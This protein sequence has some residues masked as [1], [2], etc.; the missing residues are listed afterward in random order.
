MARTTP[1]LPGTWQLL[2]LISGGSTLALEVAWLK[3]FSQV[4]GADIPALT[5]VTAAL[6]LGLAA[7]NTIAARLAARV[8]SPL[9]A[10]SAV[11]IAVAVAAAFTL[12][13]LGWL[14]TFLAPLYPGHPTFSFELLRFVGASSILLVPT[15]LMGL[16]LPLL[17]EATRRRRGLPG[18][19]F[20]RL[21]AANTI[22]AALGCL[23]AGFVLIPS[24]GVTFGLLAATAGHAVNALF[25][26]RLAAGATEAEPAAAPSGRAT[27]T[28]PAAAGAGT[29][30]P[31]TSRGLA[32]L[33]P[34]LLGVP[35]I[36]YE[37]TW[38]RSLV[39][40][41]GSTTYA[42][43]ILL[44]VF[45]LGLGAGPLLVA[46][47]TDRVRHPWAWVAGLQ[48]AIAISAFGVKI[49]VGQLP[50]WVGAPLARY[51]QSFGGFMMV[52]ASIA[53]MVLIV[54][55]LLLGCAFAFAARAVQ[56]SFAS[57]G[58]GAGT[59]LGANT[60]GNTTGSLAAT[61]VLIPALGIQGSITVASAL[62]VGLGF[63]AAWL[64]KP[65][66]RTAVI[67]GAAALVWAGLAVV[68]PRW[69]PLLI[70]SGPFL[71][72]T[73]GAAN[74]GARTTTEAAGVSV[75]A[76]AEG[77]AATV[78]VM[79][80]VR[81]ERS[82]TLNGKTTAST[83]NDIPT[84]LLSGHLP[85]LLA[86]Q[87]KNV[88]VIG[89]G[90]GASAAAV[91]RH[92]VERID[93]AE[94]SP[95]VVALQP[96]FASVNRDILTDPRVRMLTID[97]RTHLTYT[98]QTYDVITSEP[99]NPW[100]AGVGNLFSREFFEACR[101]HLAPGGVHAQWLQGYGLSRHDVASVIATFRAVY[102]E[103]TI[104]EPAWGS[105]FLLVAKRDGA[106][107][108]GDLERVWSTAAA[109]LATIGIRAPDDLLMTFLGGPALAESVTD[110]TIVT[111][112]NL[113]LEFAVARRVREVTGAQ[114]LTE[115]SLATAEGVGGLRTVLR[116]DDDATG[117]L[118]RGLA[119]RR[120]AYT[121][122]ANDPS[123]R[124]EKT[125]AA[126]HADGVTPEQGLQLSRI[127][128]AGLQFEIELFR[129]AQAAFDAEDFATAQKLLEQVLVVSPDHAEALEILGESRFM[130]GNAT[131]AIEALS[132]AVARQPERWRAYNILGAALATAGRTTD[133]IA[134][135][136][137]VPRS[138][139]EPY[140]Q[141][142]TNLARARALVNGS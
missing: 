93:V 69:D 137:R 77:V 78:M 40:I 59:F 142:Q 82:L 140:E 60:L 29:A 68:V 109:D 85:L 136:E 38:S 111:D 28:R 14:P 43:S 37:A 112:D 88:L 5:A 61:F 119:R 26:F 23:V 125:L 15:T 49:L 126:L 83:V 114:Y 124:F 27:K 97:G 48:F 141:A 118:E 24:L 57:G 56:E 74:Y 73:E 12:P 117:R 103:A 63:W 50:L 120:A 98:D 72:A 110:G 80:D 4:L 3:R 34:F 87:A 139:G 55:T 18:E 90:C 25:A 100:I 134:A 133:A 2:A 67:G 39:L 113:H 13:A 22:G 52:E 130:T 92:P 86:P 94:I 84:E 91:A 123:H 17:T 46:R 132:R 9:R 75:L 108:L 47:A 71:T 35:T 131:G 121:A 106:V 58:E 33:F 81:G 101:R 95:E 32:V 19:S 116:S 42:Y 8:A 6:F 21:Y 45:I 31:R 51:A 54:P 127:M 16:G 1:A 115:R 53:A 10:F 102:P 76:H 138:A 128:F 104:W 65:E 99:S 89:L 79:E 11:E 129:R 135:F 66:P 36:V 96:L 7:G 107:T 30:P 70:S 44:A 41:L 122:W 105:D 20:N 64:A 62:T